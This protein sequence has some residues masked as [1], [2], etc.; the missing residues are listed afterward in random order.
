MRQ[1]RARSLRCPW[2]VVGLSDTLLWL[3]SCRQPR[4]HTPEPHC[5]QLPLL[6]WQRWPGA[7]ET[8]SVV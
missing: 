2:L 4:P 5:L 8:G 3:Q 6:L 7:Q 1:E